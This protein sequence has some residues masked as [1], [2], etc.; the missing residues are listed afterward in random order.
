VDTYR[1]NY[2][3]NPAD[4]K[5]ASNTGRVDRSTTVV[6]GHKTLAE[7]EGYTRT[8]SQEHMAIGAIKATSQGNNLRQIA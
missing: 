8:V 6:R 4:L 5:C 3:N 1:S 2:D 7:A